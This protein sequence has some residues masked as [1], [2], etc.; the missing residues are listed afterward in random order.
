MGGGRFR[1]VEQGPPEPLQREAVPAASA[2]RKA[3]GAAFSDL[4]LAFRTD[5]ARERGLALGAGVVGLDVALDASAFNVVGTAL[6]PASAPVAEVEGQGSPCHA[7]QHL[8]G[9]QQYRLDSYSVQA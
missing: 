8:H 3:M 1:P 7:Y 4:T 5:A 2:A 6:V 9:V